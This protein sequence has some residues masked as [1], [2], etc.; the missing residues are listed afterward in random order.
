MATGFGLRNPR[1]A[2]G[3]QCSIREYYVPASYGTALYE[4]DVVELTTTTG[5]MDGLGEVP[6]IQAAASGDINLGVV[7]GFKPSPAI[8]YRGDFNPASTAR[9]VYVCDDPDAIYEA[10]EDAVGGSVTQALI[11]AMTNVNY[12]VAA[13]SAVTG[14]SGTMVDSST[15]TASA[16]DLKIVGVKRD[17]VNA[18]AKSGGAV[19]LV[20][21]LSSAIRAT[22]S[23]S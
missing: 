23:Q 11:G 21:I 8:V 14:E 5:A 10:Q 2:D 9:Y 13:G 3:S 17:G 19:L 22:D 20:K 6:T 7:T 16:A 1:R 18:G 4:G 12:I 15:T